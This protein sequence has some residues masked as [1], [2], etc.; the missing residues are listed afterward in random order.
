V[1]NE[2]PDRSG[3]DAREPQLLLLC[4]RT[5]LEEE[6]AHRL[7]RLLQRPLA[8]ERV[9]ALSDRHHVSALLYHHLSST[10]P[11]HVPPEILAGLRS[12]YLHLAAR[13]MRI[14]G[15]ALPLLEALEEAG[16]PA[17][18]WKGPA[19]AYS[20][21]PSPELRTFTDLDLVI[22]RQDV[23]AVRRVMEDQGYRPRENTAAPDDE[24]FARGSENVTMVHEESVTVVDVHWGAAK[25]Y[26][27]RAMDAG[28]LWERGRPLALAGRAIRAV[29]PG[30]ML[31]ALCAHGAKH[32]P[33]PWPTLKWVTDIE[34]ILR[35]GSDTDWDELMARVEGAGIRRMFLLGIELARQLL[36]APLPRSLS[37][38]I[39]GEPAIPRLVHP[40]RTRILERQPELFSFQDRLGFDLAIRERRLDRVR[41]LGSRLVAP[42]ERDVANHPDASPLL[43]IPLRLF[44]LG[45][46]Y[47]LSPS[48]G[49][50]LLT[51]GSADPTRPSG[52]SGRG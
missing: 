33:F 3:F 12:R 13:N 16:A 52:P 28:D 38:R 5:R 25:R 1:R 21:Y 19:L 34:A 29:P 27:S 40:I 7:R 11:E 49:K 4:A 35:T 42:S 51:G 36:E 23:P 41:Y 10:A 18:V 9:L 30:D 43:R 47:L 48:R 39:D 45:R 32:G 15:R 2:A 46:E 50:D 14:V 6:P 26:Q 17:A 31:P 44:R 24:V 8:W 37:D 22:R 20:V